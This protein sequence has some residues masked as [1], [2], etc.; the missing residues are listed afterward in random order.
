MCPMVHV[1]FF[2]DE[3]VFLSDA[4]VI[5]DKSFL[6]KVLT[7]QLPVADTQYLAVLAYAY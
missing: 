4:M 6:L 1:F 7:L 5:I 2:L 3:R